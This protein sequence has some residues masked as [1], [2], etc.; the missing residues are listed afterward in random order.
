MTASDDT[1]AR[2]WDAAS[3]RP[4]TEWL[5][6]DARVATAKL[7][8]DG[9]RLITASLGRSALIYEVPNAPLPVPDWL[10]QLAEALAGQR[11]TAEGT[12]QFLTLS[13]L[14]LLK[15]Q[16]SNLAVTN[17]YGQWLHWFFEDRD[18][19]T[20]SPFSSLTLPAYHRQR[21]G[22]EALSK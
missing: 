22:D 6:H 19:R 10:P 8:P 17:F 21:I 4:L 9:Q 1:T 20:I 7:S 16:S 2:V 15:G 18:T 12:R 11:L 5:T 14:W 13:N 3:G